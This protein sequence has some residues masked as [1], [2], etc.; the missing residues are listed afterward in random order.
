MTPISFR[1]LAKLLAICVLALNL[2]RA[3]TARAQ[4]TYVRNSWWTYQQDCN[5]DGCQAGQL[6][7]NLARLNWT[8]VVTNCDGVYSV[9][10]IVYSK[11][12]SSSTWTPLFTNA[13]HS[14]AGC[15]I[16]NSQYYDVEMGSNC[17]VNDYKIELYEAG[18]TH[19]DYVDSSTNDVTLSQHHEQLLSQDICED[20]YF[21]TARALEGSSGSIADDNTYATKEPG[22]PNHAGNPGG[23][24]LWYAWIAP[25]N[26]PVTF[27]TTGSTFDT[28][29]AVYTGSVVSNLAL[30][31]S[32][33]DINGAAER[34]SLVTFTPVKGTTY[35]IAVDGFGG[36]SGIVNLNWNQTGGALPDLIIWGPSANPTTIV[37]TFAS[38]D[39][40]VVE[41]CEPVGTR[42]LLSFTTETRNIGGGDLV[43]GNPAT[44]SLFVWAI[45]HAHYHFEQFA[46]YALLDANSNVVASGHK[47]GFC[48]EDVQAWTNT[49]PQAKYTCSNQG[50]QS[51]WADVYSAGLPCQY[52]DVTGVAPGQYTL[53][54]IVNPD[55]VL[56]ESNTNNNTTLVPVSIQ[57]VTCTN[58]PVNDNFANA[59]V[60]TN[61][62]FVYTEFNNCATKETGEPN[63]L[64]VA[65]GH[66]VWFTW[67]P[68][69]S[70]TIV[71]DTKRSDFDTILAV[72]TGNTVSN[73]TLV[74]SN[75]DIV[76][77]NFIQSQLSFAAV[78]GTTY[79]MVVDGY[80]YTNGVGSV[81]TVVFNLQPPNNDDFTNALPIAGTSGTTSG[82][83]I[84]A[85]KEPYEPSHAGDVGGHSVWFIW[86]APTN[87][88]VNFDTVG[89][90]F[91]TTL[92]VYTGGVRTNATGAIGGFTNIVSNV[93]DL[94][95][96]GALTSRVGFN[97]V[98]GTAYK[99]AVD[100]FAGV[101]GNYTLSW[102]MNSSLGIAPLANGNV[103]VAL[104]GVDW[105]RYLLLG[106][107][108]LKTWYTN[109]A[110]ITMSEGLHLYTN[111]PFTNGAKQEFYRAILTN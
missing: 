8:P 19:P 37:R 53:Q 57:P 82:Y 40:E 111:S 76:H 80:Y 78:A 72:Y 109:A 65:A 9:F 87:G 48:L 45:C 27:D 41:G 91:A 54:M 70:Q 33:D 97:A 22:E 4:T 49:H 66:S 47:V 60:V 62:P 84:N 98:A 95:G 94:E 44:N 59:I 39:C 108:N 68:A 13:V 89:S 14:I 102:W 3:T 32:N 92:A 11:P 30:V 79:H 67:T 25:T 46:S 12:H 34:Q 1:R 90:D 18:N 101:A 106:S 73:L 15:S 43:M 105:Q 51:G 83:N 36:A 64:G 110:T 20:D 38:T 26:T 28:L 31:V 52:I 99:I 69:T 42:T 81:G 50:I 86:V 88:P 107:T 71:V 58:T 23:K 10:E 29:L 77:D 55:N 7:G 103:Q 85:S 75:D 74:A 24:S 96:G 21:A 16:L 93:N 61:L 100:G 35:H 17:A 63:H 104:A 5:G 6:P 56:P 2:S